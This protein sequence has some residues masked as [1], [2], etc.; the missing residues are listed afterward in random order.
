MPR[1]RIGLPSK[2]TSPATGRSRPMIERGER[3]LAAPGL[4]DEREHLALAHVEGDAVDRAA[5]C[6]CR[7][8]PSA[9]KWTCR[10]STSSSGRGYASSAPRGSGIRPTFTQPHAAGGRRRRAARRDR[11]QRSSATSQR[12]W[13]GHPWAMCCGSGGSPRAPTGA[14]AKLGR[15]WSGRRPRAPACT[16]GCG[17]SNTTSLGPSSTIRPAYMT[18]SRSHT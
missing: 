3:G 9:P 6:F 14:C 1:P 13:N 11:R 16:G 2:R 12:R 7:G 17:C 5:R 10:S 18:A 15:R 4:T 8:R